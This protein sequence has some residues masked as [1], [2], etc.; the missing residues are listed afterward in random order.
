MPLL[1]G[2]EGSGG[3]RQGVSG[4]AVALRAASQARARGAEPQRAAA[5]SRAPAA[6]QTLPT[7]DCK[8]QEQQEARRPD[9]RQHS[10]GVNDLAMI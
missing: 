1:L 10:G 4:V 7:Y 2:N 3:R 9:S 5:A 6:A 8:G